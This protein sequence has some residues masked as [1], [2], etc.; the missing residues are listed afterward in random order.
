MVAHMTPLPPRR[1][2]QQVKVWWHRLRGHNVRD[3][4]HPCGQR[5]IWCYDCVADL[6]PWTSR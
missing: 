2:A 5:R 4:G 3:L 6:L 1:S